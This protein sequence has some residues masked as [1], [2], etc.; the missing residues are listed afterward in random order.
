M[1]ALTGVRVLDLSLFVQGAQAGL[2]LADLGADV[3][4]IELPGRGD[5]ARS[6]PVGPD[7]RRSAFFY[8]LNRGKRSVVLDLRTQGG[9][10]AFGRLLETADVLLSNFQPGTLDRW[11]LGYEALALLY[12]RLIYATGSAFGPVGPDADRE[13]ADLSGQAV[14]GLISVTGNAE[15]LPSPAGAVIADHS[16]AQNL[17]CG[18]LAAL[19]ARE[20]SGRGQRVDVSLLGGQ[21]WA[22]ASELTQYFMTGRLTSRAGQGHPI[23]RGLWQVFATADGHL[24]MAGAGG[25][26]WPGFCRALDRLDLATDARFID[27]AIAPANQPALQAILTAVFATRSTTEWCERLRAEGQRYAPVQDYARV[28]I[29][30]QAWANGYLVTV[31]HPEWG[32]MTAI[33]SPIRLSDTPAEPSGVAPQLGQHTEAVLLEAGFSWEELAELREQGAW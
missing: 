12:P 22:Q 23:L 11:G 32:P 24:I 17:A 18:I 5:A 3:I 16:A 9:R 25:V 1:G 4:K 20:R 26:L 13:G 2:L 15:G 29:D 30:P 27:G 31:E 7:D 10:R 33:G 19:F 21:V 28:A 8:A 14:G 6:I